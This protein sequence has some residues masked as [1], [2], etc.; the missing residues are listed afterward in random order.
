MF[1]NLYTRQTDPVDAIDINAQTA[2]DA[3]DSVLNGAGQSQH[4]DSVDTRIV[5]DVQNGTGAFI[6][7]QN[8]V[9]GFPVLN[10]MPDE[11]DTDLDGMPDDWETAHG[12]NPNDA[13]DGPVILPTGYSVLE[14]YLNG[15]IFASSGNVTVSGRIVNSRGIGIVHATVTIVNTATGA[16]RS[17]FTGPGGY[18]VIPDV[19]TYGVYTVAAQ[20]YHFTFSGAPQVLY[21]TEAVSD[22]NF[23]SEN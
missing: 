6:N 10:S 22:L 1:A 19:P 4:R 20:H 21:V 11:P 5:S 16:S 18:Y 7:S 2:P 13:A 23:V 17:I 9:G 8:D 12:L 14:I 3:Y 15:G